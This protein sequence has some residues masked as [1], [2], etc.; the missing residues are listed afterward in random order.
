[1]KKIEY[2]QVDQIGWVGNM[3]GDI[4]PF[5]V[6][7]EMA[8]VTWYR[9]GSREFNGKYVIEIGY[10]EDVEVIEPEKE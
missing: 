5:L 6:N 10:G 1:M 9:Q 7:G 2:L 8:H 4:E 3:N